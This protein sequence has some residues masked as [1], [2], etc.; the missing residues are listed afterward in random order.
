MHP[1]YPSWIEIPVEDLARALNFYRTLFGLSDT[2][3]FDHDPNMQGALLRP[4]NKNQGVPG[5]SLVQTP[6]QRP[7]P[8]GVRLNFHLGPYAALQQALQRVPQL[9]GQVLQPI[10][11]DGDGV[12]YAL[13]TDSEGNCFTLSA[14]QEGA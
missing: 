2:P 4:S 9:N 14:Y 6:Q 13:V 5:V 7:S 12:Q 11:D 3:T 10:A 8:Q 1:L